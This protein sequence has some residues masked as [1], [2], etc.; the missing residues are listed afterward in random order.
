MLV[1]GNYANI[2]GMMK[3]EEPK[4]HGCFLAVVI[5]LIVFTVILAVCSCG[6]SIVPIA[7]TLHVVCPDSLEVYVDGLFQSTGSGDILIIENY[8]NVLSIGEQ[9][10]VL[11]PEVSIDTLQVQ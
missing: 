3:M 6:S 10:L 4:G 5:C 8:P 9:Y 2:E 1:T 11:W 7:R